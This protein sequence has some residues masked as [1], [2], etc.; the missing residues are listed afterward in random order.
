M[1]DFALAVRG[2]FR[3][4][5]ERRARVWHM[6]R[7]EGEHAAE[8]EDL[9]R[10]AR[11]FR[12]EPGPGRLILARARGVDGKPFWAGLS[13]RRF[14]EMHHWVCGGTGS[15]KSFWALA[16]LLLLLS[17]GRFPVLILDFK[18][19]LTA[20]ILDVL[21]PALCRSPGG[22][23]LLGQLRVIRPFSRYLPRL[24]LTCPEPGVPR[25]IQAFTI[26]STIEE[27]LGADLGH[28]MT[29][30]LLRLVALAIE[31]RLP[32]TA[33]RTWLEDPA[34]LAAAA[35]RSTDRSLR[36]YVETLRARENR[37]SI[38]ALLAR[39]DA[40]LFLP[41]V[42]RMLQAPDCVSFGTALEGGVTVV[43]LGEPPAGAERLTR[44]LGGAILGK[45]MRSILSRDVRAD[46]PQTYV[47]L[48][49]FQEVLMAHQTEQ[50]AR[51]L[52][53]ARY[54]RVACTFINQQAAQLEPT[55]VRLLRTNCGLEVVFR[56]NLEDA[57]AYAHALPVQATT[58]RAAAER[59]ALVEQL[60]RLERRQLLLWVKGPVRAQVVRS[61]RI[62]LNHLQRGAAQ[63]PADVWERIHRG[64]VAMDDDA[65]PD[66][67]EVRDDAP[68]EDDFLRPTG[69]SEGE[70]PRLG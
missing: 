57:R 26:A 11:E 69:D 62:D 51:L 20:L 50:L 67:Q 22:E 58:I 14:L 38:D 17:D 27:S 7:L 33:V 16:V 30:V 23:R 47:V 46:S 37:A 63:V 56:C 60:T 44:F 49:E 54:K 68:F 3:R 15:G 9:A 6:R 29:R 25:E 12:T 45:L 52:A 19:E 70:L 5:D 28:R 35:Q 13:I 55:L 36:R 48:E 34:T 24:N 59:Q 53:L 1:R 8:R 61:P 4:R 18:G 39:L 10:F 21:I 40:F 42:R 65:L 41:T 66:S 43:G 32:L 31:L 2:M 64:T